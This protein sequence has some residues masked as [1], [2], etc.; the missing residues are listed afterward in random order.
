[1]PDWFANHT[2]TLDYSLATFLKVQ[3]MAD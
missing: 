1:V 2:R 3:G